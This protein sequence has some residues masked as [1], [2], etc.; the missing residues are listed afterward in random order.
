MI[1]QLRKI[2][3]GEEKYFKKWGIFFWYFHL[4][5]G[6]SAAGKQVKISSPFLKCNRCNDESDTYDKS[7]ES[8]DIKMQQVQ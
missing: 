6:P 4:A 7:E 3:T 2:K 5:V 8:L 1:K